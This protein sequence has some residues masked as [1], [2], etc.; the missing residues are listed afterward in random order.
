MFSYNGR[1]AF[2]R[3]VFLSFEGVDEIYI[4]IYTSQIV[5]LFG[6]NHECE[7]NKPPFLYMMYASEC[8]YYI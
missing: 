2:Q 4:Y 7:P 6:S 8:V 1:E 3:D 5:S